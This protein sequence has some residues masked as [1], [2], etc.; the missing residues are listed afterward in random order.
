MSRSTFV[1]TE[2]L[3]N[4]GFVVNYEKS[5]LAPFQRLEHLGL[6]IDSLTM[7]MKIGGGGGG[8]ETSV[9]K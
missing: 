9:T 1:T 3:E 5:V 2:L 6:V 8:G 4:L 7:T